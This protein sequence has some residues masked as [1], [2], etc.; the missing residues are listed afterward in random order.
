MKHTWIIFRKMTSKGCPFFS[1]MARRN[2]GIITRIMT[3]VAV[4]VPSG[5]LRK[6]KAGSPMRAPAPKHTSC[7]LVRL[8][9]TLVLI[10]VMCISVL[11]SNSR[12]SN[13]ACQPCKELVG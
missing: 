1:Y 6:M 2:A 12:N 13:S 5:S 7:R 4:L 3:I 9:S 10:F 11:V 8:N